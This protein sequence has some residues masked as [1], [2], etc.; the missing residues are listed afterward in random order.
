[1]KTIILM[2][3]LLAPAWATMAQQPQA[4]AEASADEL[5]AVFVTPKGN[6]WVT[7]FP[8]Q[9]PVT[10]ANF[11][12]LARRGYYD[13]LTFH[14]VIPNFMIQG[15]DPTG[16]GREGP[17]YRFEDEFSPLLRHE[18][19][20]VLSMANS[21]P[22]TNGSQFFITHKDT[23]WLDDRHSVFG[24]VVEGQDVVDAISKGDVMTAVV[25]E[26]DASG[27]FEQAKH[28]LATWNNTLDK[29]YPA[30]PSALDEAQATAIK[31]QAP[32]MRAKA[33]TLR[34][35]LKEAAARR[36][37][38]AAEARASFQK[39]YQEAQE[40]GTTAESGLKYYDTAVGEGAQPEKTGRVTL[41]CTGWLEDGTKF[42]SSH[43]GA[44]KPISQKTTGFVPG[45]TEGIS[46]MKVGGQ[47]VLIIPG[48]LGYGP[49]GNPR[50]KIPPNATL[51]FEVELL[52]VQ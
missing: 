19:A 13:G 23:P 14:R 52:G 37:A 16:T 45:F 51:V 4:S 34:A 31:E 2:T 12:N 24:R 41:H 29:K 48:K 25:I 40:K 10:V 15:G 6:I 50:A 5:L 18:A 32:A 7:L 33:A 49:S 27:V 46:T 38:A 1:M 20:G 22:N 26:G 11:V 47:R 30:R 43:D 3:L 42:Y 28:K 21:G 9:A 17:G 44:G 35:E 39:M 8:D 36:Q